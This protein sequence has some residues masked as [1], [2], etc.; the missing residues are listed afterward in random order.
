M[1]MSK[2]YV[3]VTKAANSDEFYESLR[4]G[5]T[6]CMF[7]WNLLELYVESV[8]LFERWKCDVTFGWEMPSRQL[9]E[10]VVRR[11]RQRRPPRR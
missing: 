9:A 4:F 7:T 10:S 1:E 5:Q 6:V 3:H 8:S 2:I 11:S